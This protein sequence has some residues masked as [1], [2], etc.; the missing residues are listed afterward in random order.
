MRWTD[1]AAGRLRPAPHPGP[2]GIPPAQVAGGRLQSLL[3]RG[4]CAD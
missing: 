1:A 2:D 3:W 4:R